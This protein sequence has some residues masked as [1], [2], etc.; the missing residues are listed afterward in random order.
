[1]LS[2]AKAAFC[3]SPRKNRVILKRIMRGEIAHFYHL[4]YYSFLLALR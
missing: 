3:V 1:M 4:R 2:H